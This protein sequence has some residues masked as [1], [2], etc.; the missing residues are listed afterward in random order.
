MEATRVQGRVKWYDAQKSFGFIVPDG[1][2]DD[3]LLHANVLHDFGVSSVVEGATITC[4]VIHTNRGAQVQK[5]VTLEVP[6]ADPIET[7]SAII[8]DTTGLEDALKTA[9]LQ[10]ARVKWYDRSKGFGFVNLFGGTVDIFVHIELLRACGFSDIERGEA[11]AVK[12][13]DGPRGLIVI[14]VRHW[15]E[16]A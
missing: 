8:E 10:P 4:D 13:M 1:G 16:A 7:L 11:L 3:M 12:T 15:D 6:K 5:I 2:G 9:K 14:E